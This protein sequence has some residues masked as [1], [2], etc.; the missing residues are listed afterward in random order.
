MSTSERRRR[1]GAL[2]TVLWLSAALAAIAFSLASTVRGEAERTSTAV[3]GL[4]SYYLATG[5]IERA[6]NW[7]LWAPSAPAGEDGR[8]RYYRQGVPMRFS[9]PSGEAVVEVIP[10]AAK[11]DVNLASPDILMTVLAG[12]GVE[13]GRATE[14]AN[15]IVDWR[16]PSPPGGFGPFDQFYLAQNPSFRARHASFQEI[17]ELLFVRGVT[18]D[19]FYGAYDRDAVTGRL[20]SR[21]GLVDC[22]SVFGSSAA[23]DINHAAAAVMVAVGV[24]PQIAARIVERRRTRPFLEAKELAELAPLIGPGFSR[25]R[26]GGNSIMTLRATASLRLP[27]GRLSDLK[28]TAGALF[29]IMP[30]GYDTP[31]HILRWYDTMWATDN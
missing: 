19:L 25:L 20:L 22:L 11:L 18:S 17:E 12:L 4:R 23:V 13:T 9:F 6:I 3:D 30:E 26:I 16:S 5:A 8:P 14:I 28:R 2:L 29:K 7:I 21:P 24:P 1:G 15:A 10:E 27:D 31:Y